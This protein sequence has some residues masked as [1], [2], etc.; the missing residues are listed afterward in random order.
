MESV[1]AQLFDGARGGCYKLVLSFFTCGA[2][3]QLGARIDGID[4]VAGSNPA[5]STKF[6][7]QILRTKS[8]ES[9]SGAI[10]FVTAIQRARGPRQANNKRAGETPALRKAE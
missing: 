4:E 2:V 6:S 9:F 3:A 1:R 8:V 7:K 5:G 10:V